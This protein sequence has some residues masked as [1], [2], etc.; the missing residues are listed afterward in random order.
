MSRT[1]LRLTSSANMSYTSQYDKYDFFNHFYSQEVFMDIS[2]KHFQGFSGSALKLIAICAMVLDHF[3]ATVLYYGI[4]LPAAPI[5]E[6]TSVWTVYTIYQ[7]LRFIGRIAF[8]IFCFLLV[9][10]FLHTSNR[11]RY[12]LR[13][14][15]FALISEIPFDLALFQSL[16]DWNHQNV[17]FTLLIGFVVIWAMEKTETL[18]F[19]TPLKV[20]AFALGC[21][22]AWLLCTDYDYKGVILITIFYVFRYTPRLRTL[23]GCVSL[24]WEAPACL[25]FFPIHL[26]NG[27]RGL[28]LKYVFYLFYP[29]HLLLFAFLV[30]LMR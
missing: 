2:A 26:Y 20:S 7:V 16:T 5:K 8:P 14:F 15:V 28:S 24:I 23:A 12:A 22:V 1:F 21:L 18:P 11:A 25:A 30:S 17:F 27:K 3:A 6:G 13:L 4:L 29:V 19:S 10:G 9:E